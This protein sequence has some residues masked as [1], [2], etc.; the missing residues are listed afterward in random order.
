[1]VGHVHIHRIALVEDRCGSPN[2]LL[3]TAAVMVWLP[4][5]ICAKVSRR[6]RTNVVPERYPGSRARVVLGERPRC[7]V[8]GA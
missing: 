1:M 2:L 4:G 7:A 3:F 6:A 8:R 5:S